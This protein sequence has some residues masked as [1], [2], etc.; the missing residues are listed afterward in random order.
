MDLAQLLQ[1]G[2]FLWSPLAFGLLVALALACVWLAFAPSRPQKEVEERLEDFLETAVALE[3]ADMRRP[4]AGRV[5]LPLLRRLLGALGRL[6]PVRAVA[7]IQVSLVRAGQPGGLTALDF[8]G[9]QVLLAA[10]AGGGYFLLQG[11]ALGFALALRN[12]FLAAAAGYFLPWYWL[13]RT[14]R[15]RQHQIVRALP[16]AL[17]MMTVGV[18]AGLAFESALLR[19][20][21]QWDNALTRE[22][23][24]TVSEM[25]V[26][27]AR[28]AALRN[29]A[30]RTGVEEL[31]TFVA[32]LIQ[33][34]QLG[35][36]IAE[37]L[38]TQ[39]AQMRTRRQQRAEELARQAGVKMVIPLVFL[40]FPA[41]LVVILGPSIP[42]FLS[43]F[44]SMGGV[45]GP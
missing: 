29:L 1:A 31:S 43:F 16:D 9:L 27:T 38:H 13:R 21:E 25:R 11:G 4:V 40:I 5:V 37:V 17:D 10:L 18:E 30:E 44:R 14:A 20:G 41:I 23:R 33:S 26:G 24:R 36:S 35:V 45:T 2:R 19:V 15:S 32:V 42:P 22:L 34:S 12:A 8:V 7:G 6:M 39:A 3:E 28:N